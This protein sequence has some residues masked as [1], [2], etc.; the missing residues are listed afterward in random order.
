MAGYRLGAVLPPYRI[1]HRLSNERG[2]HAAVVGKVRVDRWMPGE[3][4]RFNKQ[5]LAQPADFPP[6]QVNDVE[7]AVALPDRIPEGRY[8]LA[9]GVVEDDHLNPVV[10]LGITGRDDDGCYPLSTTE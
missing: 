6:G 3:I 2:D 7:D 10:K 8:T 4:E 9:M 5:F 1:A